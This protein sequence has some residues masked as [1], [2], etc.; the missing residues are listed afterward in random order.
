MLLDEKCNILQA[1]PYHKSRDS[2][3]GIGWATGWTIGVLGFDSWRGL[4]I[5]LF[6]TASRTVLGPTQPPIQWV[7]GALSLGLKRLV[8]EADHSSSS[9]AEVKECVELCLHSPNT[10]SWCDA[11]LKKHRDNFNL[12]YHKSDIHST[13]S[14]A[15]AYIHTF[16][17]YQQGII[18][19]WIRKQNYFPLHYCF[20]FPFPL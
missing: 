20:A 6:I 11:Q 7:P 13:M 4:G 19:I 10:P 15:L 18:P 17:P 9:S 5:F 3:V 16:L 14:N 12:T 2:S 1:V 8:R